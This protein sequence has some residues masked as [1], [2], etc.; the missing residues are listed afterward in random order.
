MY[1]CG[2]KGHC[3]KTMG[4]KGDRKVNESKNIPIKTTVK[5]FNVKNV[6]LCGQA[7]LFEIT[8]DNWIFIYDITR[9]TLVHTQIFEPL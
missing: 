9:K 3:V 2:L 6:M 1:C 5:L 8:L 4:K 7:H